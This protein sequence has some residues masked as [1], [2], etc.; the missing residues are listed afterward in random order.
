VDG[1]SKFILDKLSISSV[2]LIF[3]R[4]Y[5][6]SI[7]SGTRKCQGSQA[8]RYLKFRPDTPLA[9]QKVMLNVEENKFQLIDL[10]Q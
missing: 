8:A 10:M 3:D 1:F 5:D 6:F 9:S 7:K 4:Y 2:Y